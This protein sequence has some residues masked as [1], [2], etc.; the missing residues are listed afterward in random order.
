VDVERPV[1]LSTDR[2]TSRDGQ[3]HLAERVWARRASFGWLEQRL[4]QS[5]RRRQ[6]PSEEQIRRATAFVSAKLPV[7][8]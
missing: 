4:L 6:C 8:G 2:E 5:G 1:A 3:E 7:T